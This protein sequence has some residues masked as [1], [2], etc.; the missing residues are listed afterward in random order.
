MRRLLAVV[1]TGFLAIA[2]CGD[3]RRADVTGP[4]PA[5]PSTTTEQ[6]VTTTA[7]DAIAAR[8]FFARD[9]KVAT[10]GRA[11][12]GSNAVSELVR[13]LLAGP[14]TFERG[15]GMR[16]EIPAGTDLL[17]ATVDDR[18]ATV[19][20]SSEFASGGGSL[21]MQLRVAQV[22]FTLTALGTVDA[23]T[24]LIDGRSVD[25]IGGEGV[26]AADLSR[27]DF[28][29]VTPM[30]LVETPVPGERVVS[31][32]AVSGISN[33][34]EAN[35]RYAITDADGLILRDGFTTATAGNGTWGTFSFTEA[36]DTSRP[37]FGAV[38]VWQDDPESGGQRDVYEVPIQIG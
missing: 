21:S 33:T 15:I 24:I 19:D 31:P 18:L 25:A 6:I 38:I 32:L 28:Q 5:G 10:A 36:F 16:T 26:P 23:V 14:S 27:D 2:A 29:N 7:G 13:H 37:G 22:V 4:A 30:I 11:I 35:V 12:S 20:L 34:F 1:L 17:G 9:E 3:G 8:V